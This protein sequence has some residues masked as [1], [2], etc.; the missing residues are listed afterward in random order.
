MVL[1][2]QKVVNVKPPVDNCIRPEAL[3]FWGCAHELKRTYA[4]AHSR[5]P[6]RKRPVIDGNIGSLRKE[7]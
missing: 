1:C 7:K 2:F 5:S 4:T 3:V 6:S